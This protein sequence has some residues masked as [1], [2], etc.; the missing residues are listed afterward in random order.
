MFNS[1]KQLFWEK[2]KGKNMKNYEKPMLVKTEQ[3]SEG[4][5]LASGSDCYTA[6]GWIAQRPQL[7]NEVYTIQLNAQ[8]VATDGHHSESRRFVVNFNL[9]VTY[10]SSGAALESG[11]GTTTLCLVYD[12][13]AGGGNYHNNASDNIGLGDLKVTAADGLEVLSV[14]VDSCD[15]HC[16]QHTW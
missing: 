1:Y 12:Y 2:E 15:H 5:Y 9:P 13:R 7:G 8:H 16:D 4:V 6:S 14:T 3:M 11:N 10:V